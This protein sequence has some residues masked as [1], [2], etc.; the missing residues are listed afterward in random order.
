MFFWSLQI[1]PS[2]GATIAQL[3]QHCGTLP[4]GP[5]RCWHLPS[6]LNRGIYGSNHWGSGRH[7]E[8]ARLAAT[9]TR[10]LLTVVEE[11]SQPVALLVFLSGQAARLAVLPDLG[12]QSDHSVL[13]PL[14]GREANS[15]LLIVPIREVWWQ[16]KSYSAAR[17]GS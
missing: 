6:A 5:L 15:Q 12:P 3:S 13:P 8:G 9:R 14:L 11:R 2:P 10:P 16:S 1:W 7:G 4:G 17:R